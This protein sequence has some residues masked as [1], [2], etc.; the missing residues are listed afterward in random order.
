[1]EWHFCKGYPDFAYTFHGYV[2]VHIGTRYQEQLAIMD[3]MSFIGKF[4]FIE[5][6][7]LQWNPDL[8]TFHQG[9]FIIIHVI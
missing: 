4:S 9:K 5:S 1:M 3:L 7:F 8:V 6:S 2:P